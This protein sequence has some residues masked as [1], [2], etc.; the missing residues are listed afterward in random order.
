MNGGV[1][2]DAINTYYCRCPAGFAGVNCE[3]GKS[4]AIVRSYTC[5]K[6]NI[7]LHLRQDISIVCYSHKTQSPCDVAVCSRDMDINILLDV[8]ASRGSRDFYTMQQFIKDLAMTLPIDN[9]VHSGLGLATFSNGGGRPAA[10]EA[11]GIKFGCVADAMMMS[12]CCNACASLFQHY[13][14]Y[15]DVHS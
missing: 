14:S 2:T 7:C 8:S 5:L 13:I 6:V 12:C 15:T 4:I 9:E 11:H 10:M 3:M 1:C